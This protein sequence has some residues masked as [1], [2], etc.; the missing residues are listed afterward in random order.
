[1]K[2]RTVFV[3]Q[4]FHPDTGEL[5]GY[6]TDRGTFTEHLE[7]AVGYYMRSL[8]EARCDCLGQMAGY[9]FYV[10]VVEE[11]PD[12]YERIVTVDHYQE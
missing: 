5:E 11:V 4:L 9:R 3:L 7:R 8:A 2:G 10:W 6:L 1:V 12:P